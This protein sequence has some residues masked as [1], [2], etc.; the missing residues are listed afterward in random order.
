MFKINP[1]AEELN[2]IIKEGNE[3]IY[4]LLSEKGKA[5]FFPEKGIIS[6][7][8][9]AKGKNINATIGSAI[10]DDGSPMRLES[11]SSHIDMDPKEVFLYAPSFGKPELR[12]IWKEMIIN[13]NPSISEEISM[14]VVTNGL[15]HGLSMAG[16]MFINPGDKII[17]SSNFWGNYKLLFVNGF[18]A[19]LELFDMF[20]EGKFSAEDLRVKLQENPGKQ[21]ILLNFP[22]NPTGY[23]PSESEMEDIT[24]VISESAEAGND[25]VVIVD[26]A[27]FG[28][29]YDEMG[30]K[31]SIFSKISSLHKNV[32]AV[33]IDGA[34]KEDYAWGLR[35]G[36]LTYGYKGGDAS[37]YSALESKTAGAV[38]GSVSNV[39]HLSQSLVL[40]SLNSGEYHDEKK[41]KYDILKSRY[42][43]IKEVISQEKFSAC[44]TA[45]PYNSG[46]F[47][48][49]ELEE[50]LDAEKIRQ[51]LLK[52]YDTGVIAM[53]QILRIAYSS[54][55]EKDIPRLFENI[56]DAC[57]DL[58]EV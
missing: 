44:F 10:D 34:T 15:T 21:I 22:N 11:I 43:K 1:Q 5:I 54:V 16:Y 40:S 24:E 33:K 57:K 4:R 17:M 13:K 14:P 26:D 46:Y 3:S 2:K 23:T 53:G 28:L 37:I 47:M 51:I 27:Y 38:R 56:Y 25:I 20:F 55:P 48:C 36:F 12:D 8:S 58:L 49:V 7:A 9:D 35:V 42:E 41:E 45:L 18:D 6:Q 30:S 29:V 31:E 52:K 32:L 39:S 50:G 19:E